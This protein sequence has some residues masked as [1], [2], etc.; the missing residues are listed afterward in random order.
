M[1]AKIYSDR[2]EYSVDG[3]DYASATYDVGAIPEK[4]HFGF[5]LYSRDE[6]K[7]IDSVKIT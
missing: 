6:H 7:I 2:A 1:T 3:S 5:A 4:G